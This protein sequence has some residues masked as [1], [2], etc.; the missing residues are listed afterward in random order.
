MKDEGQLVTMGQKAGASLSD[1]AAIFGISIETIQRLARRLGLRL[2][3]G[4]PNAKN[5]R[6]PAKGER[7]LIMKKIGLGLGVVLIVLTLPG[8]VAFAQTAPVKSNTGASA[9]P[10]A[11]S[12][13]YPLPRSDDGSPG[14]DV[15]GP[16][17]STKQVKPIPCG[18]AASE[19]DGSTT[20][21]GIEGDSKRK[22]RRKQKMKR[23]E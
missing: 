6:R 15:A 4:R 5:C 17:G 8:L 3:T 23:Q 22:I 14:L 7:E 19:T 21:V 16:D 20:C 2:P 9:P 10:G 13:S 1:A 12:T 18:T 11:P